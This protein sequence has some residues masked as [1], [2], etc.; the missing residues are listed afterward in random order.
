MTPLIGFAIGMYLSIRTG[1]RTGWFAFPFVLLLIVWAWFGGFSGKKIYIF[2]LV[3]LPLIGIFLGS[4]TVS[5][6]LALFV[7]EISSYPWHGGIASDTAVGLRITFY[8]LG[9]YYFSESPLFGWGDKG[10]LGI[11]DAA[12]VVQF[13]TLYS[14]DFAYNAL[15]HS[16]WT[17]QAVRFG[18]FGLISV[19]WVFAV[20]FY[21]FFKHFK[22]QA[23]ASLMG[24]AFLMC[25]LAASFSTEIYSSK[26]MIT[27]T[28]IIISGLLADTLRDHVQNSA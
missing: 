3:V 20:P 4:N 21:T 2:L 28:V 6:R 15:F 13:S 1:S 12:E 9:A 23:L 17:T 25:Q 10:Y 26:G 14:R 22:S 19:F 18:L 11:K 27:F 16:E 7:D 5:A 8:R 24:M